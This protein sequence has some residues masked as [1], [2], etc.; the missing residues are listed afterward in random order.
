MSIKPMMNDHPNMRS[1]LKNRRCDR[2]NPFILK[3]PG[4]L[5]YMGSS[6]YNTNKKFALTWSGAY[7]G[8]TKRYYVFED[9][10]NRNAEVFLRT[11][12]GEIR[13]Y[14]KDFP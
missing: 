11:H 4:G 14:E 8:Y 12:A 13:V 7:S 10:N 3:S 6:L 9:A 1:I 5:Y 2:A